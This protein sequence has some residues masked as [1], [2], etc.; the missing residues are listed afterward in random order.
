[1]VQIERGRAH[2]YLCVDDFLG[3]L[4]DARSLATALELGLVDHL[5]KRES[6][7]FEAALAATKTTPVGLRLLVR[8]LRAN[9]IVEMNDDRLQLTP[10]FR[11][12]LEFRD[13]L[14]AKIDFAAAV[15]ADFHGLF[16]ELLAAP[17]SFMRQS[18]VFDMFR[19]DRSTHPGPG[20]LEATRRWV[21]FTTCLTRYEAA[22]CLEQY[23]FGTHRHVLDIG[24]NSGE[25]ALA[26]CGGTPDTRVT[27]LDLPLVCEVGRAHVA[28]KDGATRI[29]FLPGDARRAALPSGPDLITFKSFLHDWVEQDAARFL[30]R[31]FEALP[32]G[33]SVLIYERGPIPD[34]TAPLPY[35]MI[36]TLMFLHFLRPPEIYCALLHKLGFV[37]IETRRIDLEMPFHLVT[38]RKPA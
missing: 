17:D 16:T 10:A 37:A 23:D 15:L 21:R 8:L 28:G 7:T 3:T 4:V 25:F 34:G 31:A 36:P 12:A 9:Q 33:G 14:V 30:A 13:L 19:Y 20:N 6:S 2:A 18:R 38:A 32:A 35:H 24:G 29:S 11:A 5:V 27:V 26:I 1:M 22:P